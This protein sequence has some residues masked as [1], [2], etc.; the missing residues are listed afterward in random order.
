M[1]EEASGDAV[2]SALT[3]IKIFRL[4]LR[5]PGSLDLELAIGPMGE[6]LADPT[7]IAH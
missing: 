4:Q 7:Q 1:C 3:I 5:P 6:H 2:K